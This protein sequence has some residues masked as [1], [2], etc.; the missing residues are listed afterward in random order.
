MCTRLR[1]GYDIGAPRFNLLPN[2]PIPRNIGRHP[3]ERIL[4]S[5]GSR[6]GR[7]VA[8]DRRETELELKTGAIMIRFRLAAIRA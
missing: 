4:M 7:D 3:A 2:H 8:P 6:R 5:L 1:A